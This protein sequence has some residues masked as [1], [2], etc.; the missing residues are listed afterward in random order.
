MIYGIAL[1]SNLGNR[2]ENLARG[3]GLVLQRTQSLLTG[4]SPVYETAPEGCAPGTAAF[5]NAVIEIDCPLEPHPLHEQLKQI[6]IELGRP[7]IHARNSPRTLDLDILYAGELRIHD[8][9]LIIPHPRL[10]ERRFVLQPLADIRPDLL[11]PDFD[12]TVSELLTSQLDEFGVC[13]RK[14]EIVPITWH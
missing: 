3:V 10:R 8:D 1:G 11:L 6:E 7:E 5:L 4:Q 9:T 13:L 2:E 12:K 14:G